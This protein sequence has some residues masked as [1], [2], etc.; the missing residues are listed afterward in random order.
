[1]ADALSTASTDDLKNIKGVCFDIDDTLTSEGKLTAPAY[2]ALWDLKEAGYTLVPL[3]GRPAGWCDHFARF[4]PIDAVVGENGAF[5]FLMKDNKRIRLDPPGSDPNRSFKIEALKTSILKRFQNAKWAS[6]Q[7]YRE[8]DLAIDI[9]EDVQPWS[10][11]NIEALLKHCRD[12]GAHAKLSSIHVNAWYG[13]FDKKTGFKFWL[14][15]GATATVSR[16]LSE[17]IFIGDS[18]ND[19]PMF[20]YF[21][22][23]VG[24]A[25]IPV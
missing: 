19:E 22:K 18:P 12:A 25:N 24:V 20:E 4:W 16:E 17:W 11:F 6:D 10:E 23:S 14:Q 9:C 5:I 15:T 3:T 2:R 8:N 21:K 7:L 1:M 13:N